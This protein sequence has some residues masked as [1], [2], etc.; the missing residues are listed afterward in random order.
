MQGRGW[1][2]NEHR[3]PA[4]QQQQEAQARTWAATAAVRGAGQ[5]QRSP[6]CRQGWPISPAAPSSRSVEKATRPNPT[7]RPPRLVY[8][9]ATGS[10]RA[11]SSPRWNP[12]AFLTFSQ[13]V[14]R[15]ESCE[16][17]ALKYHPGP[18][19]ARRSSQSLAA[20][21]LNPHPPADHLTLTSTCPPIHPPRA[22]QLCHHVVR[23]G[24]R[25]HRVQ[26]HQCRPWW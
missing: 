1:A 14:G 4:Q 23:V 19:P 20:L 21:Y 2:C 26:R 11:I 12:W 24:R 8:F 10:T 25:A 16:S 15:T 5:K 9:A 22:S 18:A 13:Y 17:S 7:R 3:Q 6:F